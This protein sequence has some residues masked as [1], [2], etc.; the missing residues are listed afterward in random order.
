MFK[1]QQGILN[2]VVS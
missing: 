2:F 1:F